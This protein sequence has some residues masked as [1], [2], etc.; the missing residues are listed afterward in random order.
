MILGRRHLVS[1]DPT[2]TQPALIATTS[3]SPPQ[4]S[5]AEFFSR[6]SSGDRL[7]GKKTSWLSIVKKVF[8]SKEASPSPSNIRRVM[9]LFS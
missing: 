8:K 4:S 2:A 5:P 6:C 1:R 7:M 9:F 3:A